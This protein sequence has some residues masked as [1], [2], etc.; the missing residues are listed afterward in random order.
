MFGQ[1]LTDVCCSDLVTRWD[2]N[3]WSSVIDRVDSVNPNPATVV[4]FSLVSATA[5]P[6]P[7]L[8]FTRA[9]GASYLHNNLSSATSSNLTD[10]NVF[11]DAL[12]TIYLSQKKIWIIFL[13]IGLLL[14][15]NVLQV[16]IIKCDWLQWSL[17]EMMEKHI[18]D[19]ISGSLD[20]KPSTLFGTHEYIATDYNKKSD[21]H[22]V[23][24]FTF[25]QFLQHLSLIHDML[26]L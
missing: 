19:R 24:I 3:F 22:K 4:S 6:S 17:I 14:R 15:W 1:S 21:I 10:S 23:L 25:S 13:L 18:G 16:R 9:V 5:V 12:L 26:I 8:S 11:L 7:L 2:S 20:F